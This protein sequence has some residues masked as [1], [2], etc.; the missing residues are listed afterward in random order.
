MKQWNVYSLEKV[1][2]NKRNTSNKI[3]TQRLL[4]QIADLSDE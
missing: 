2:N 3:E 1:V 4:S